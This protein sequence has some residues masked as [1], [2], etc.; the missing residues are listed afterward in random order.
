MRRRDFP[1]SL[2]IEDAWES[3]ILRARPQENPSPLNQW[4]PNPVP[5][6]FVTLGESNSP[7]ALTFLL[8]NFNSLS[9]CPNTPV[10]KVVSI[11]M[12]CSGCGKGEGDLSPLP[13]YSEACE[14]MTKLFFYRK[15]S[16]RLRIG[17]SR[18]PWSKLWSSAEMGGAGNKLMTI[19]SAHKWTTQDT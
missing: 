10:K 18:P 1:K 14:E 17:I 9:N 3:V 13:L 7:R 11:C 15:N 5:P 16:I 6:S 2:I 4:R 12:A 19:R 8:L